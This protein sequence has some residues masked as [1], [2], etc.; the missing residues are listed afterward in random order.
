[1]VFKGNLNGTA[2]LYTNG[3]GG[4]TH[5]TTDLSGSGSASFWSEFVQSSSSNSLAL[6]AFNNFPY[7]GSSMPNAQ[8]YSL[9][10]VGAKTVAG[11]SPSA[12]GVSVSF[13]SGSATY[14]SPQATQNAQ[15]NFIITDTQQINDGS[16][17]IKVRIR[18]TFNLRV[19]NQSTGAMKTITDGVFVGTFAKD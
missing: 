6:V 2:V 19:V 11:F 8:F 7:T 16:G 4:V 12:N 13:R 18:A 14:W 3:V 9:F 10:T 15:S 1:M 5:D 17:I